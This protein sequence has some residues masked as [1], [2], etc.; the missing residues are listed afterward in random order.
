MQQLMD[1]YQ[2]MENLKK[3]SEEIDA[4][5]SFAPFIFNNRENDLKDSAAHQVFFVVEF[6]LSH[7]KDIE[8]KHLAFVNNIREGGSDMTM[9]Y[10]KRGV[11][12]V[13]ASSKLSK[14]PYDKYFGAIAQW[15]KSTGASDKIQA[16]ITEVDGIITCLILDNPENADKLQKVK[17]DYMT[18]LERNLKQG[19][20][21]ATA[22][23]S[24]KQTRSAVS[25][26][27]SVTIANN[28]E[29][30]SNPQHSPAANNQNQNQTRMQPQGGKVFA[31]II[32]PLLTAV[33]CGIAF[34][35][36]FE[37]PFIFITVIAII[38]LFVGLNKFN[39]RCE[40]CGVCSAF[41]VADR[42]QIGK[43]KVKVQRTLNTNSTR[44][45]V[46]GKASYTHSR[47]NVL[48]SADE[49]TYKELYQCKDCGY[50]KE[51][52]R[53]VIDDKIRR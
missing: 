11:E 10:L 50:Q 42:V 40:K 43:E 20:A 15:G 24:P 14:F 3:I 39:G 22:D 48:V 41:Y 16:I 51:G 28:A 17:K 33:G 1:A 7:M 46:K 38:W 47:R 37:I 5:Q 31:A 21:I 9:D 27:A 4:E 12:K 34:F 2:H 13:R 45:S 36:S 25:S 44:I 32:L 19:N 6:F 53:R 30:F 29:Q 26:P 35:T 49:I 52:I 18:F 8:D 23:G